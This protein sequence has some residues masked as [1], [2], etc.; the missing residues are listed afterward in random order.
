MPPTPETEH[1]R[2]REEQS[3]RARGRA[4][5]S[6]RPLARLQSD[7]VVFLGAVG[8]VVAFVAVT[9]I[10]GD[11]ARDVFSV[12]SDW[13]LENLGWMYIGGISAAFIFLVC[14]AL[15]R[16]GRVKLGDD[17]D[18][19]EHSFPVWFSMLFAAGLGAVLMFWGVAEPLNHAYNVPMADADPMSD[20]AI[21]E[22]FV[23][24]YYHFALHMWVIFVLPGLALGYFIY[25]RKLPP[26]LSSVFSPLLGGKI[27]GLPG[28]LIDVLAIVGTTFGIAVS[29]GLGTLQINSG[30]HQLWGV[31]EISWM[32]LLI[33]VTITAIGC[34]SVATGLERGVKILSNVNIG[35]AMALM[36]FVLLAGPTLTLIKFLVESFGLYV[37]GLPEVMF[38]TDSFNDNPGWQGK[39]TVFY[40]AW[41]ICWSP[42]A[43]MF[44]AR[45]SRGRTVREYIFGALAVPSL[46]SVIWFGI[47]GRAGIELENSDPGVL[48]QPVVEEG[49]VPA[50]LFNLL[51]AYPLT[52]VVSGF[53]V[54]IIA[55]FFITSIDSAAMVNDMIVSGAEDKTPTWY[56]VMWGALIG[57]VAAALLVISPESGIEALQEVAIIVALP[58]FLTNFV[59]MYAL[60]KGMTDDAASV[61]RVRTR[62]WEVTDSAE[63][64]EEHEARPAPGYDEEGN[65]LERP[66][67]ERDEEGHYLVD[68]EVFGAAEDE[69]FETGENY[70]LIEQSRPRSAEEWDD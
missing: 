65:A 10:A 17:E 36:A 12:A 2:Q 66:V 51:D 25:K 6:S 46:F 32:Q 1:S 64:L 7:P 39:W 52:G 63:K 34:V 60:V 35:A 70:R 26:R 49:N 38:W 31:P 67:L 4:A 30:M 9:I 20:D 19:P 28:K 40:W 5:A 16:Y 37:T 24:T 53:A 59:M 47:F 58:F 68:G 33:V 23:F 15:S 54:A 50:A 11:S 56:R 57:A 8:F 14:I 44:I 62:Q 27:Y 21:R 69:D 41:T 55:V 29:V 42:F 3:G 45:I 22:A 13:L 61:R 48:T 43:G 18:E